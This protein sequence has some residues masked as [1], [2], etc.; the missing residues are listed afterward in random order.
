MKNHYLYSI[1]LILFGSYQVN[2]QT[3]G[4][5]VHNGITRNYILYVPSSYQ[6]G[7]SWPLVHVLHGFT[8]SASTIMNVSGFNA[9]AD[10]AEFIV[11]YPNGVGNAWNTNSGMT[12][13]STAD[14][15]GFIGALTDT[16]QL[17]YNIDTNR[18]YS[19]GF[20]AGGY[21]SHRLACEAPRCYAAVASVA[22]TM[23]VNAFNACAPSRDISVMQIHGT[24][25]AIV[26][27]NGSAQ[28]GKSVDD[29]IG[30]WVGNN[31]CATPPAVQLLPNI[32]TQDNSTV[33][34]SVYAPCNNATEVNLYKVIGGGHQWPGTNSLLGG[35]GAINRDISASAEI[36][37]F[38]SRFS[39]PLPSS[40]NSPEFATSADFVLAQ[41][42][43]AG[44]VIINHSGNINFDAEVYDV[45]GK[46]MLYEAASGSFV[47]NQETLPGGIYILKA[48]AGNSVKTFKV[49][50]PF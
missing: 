40:I 21:M 9:I 31:S 23:S 47:L 25:D 45:T 22:G 41:D 6:P 15:I 20:S 4:T 17:L 5:I 8:Q 46:K 48:I 50:I 32:N 29:V 35:L 24:S 26:S 7:N 2:S 12:G 38:F 36:W 37:N 10:T 30:L 11:A 13:G 19:C 28:G 18:V 44:T 14:D 34:K 39:C 43:T 27:Y 16:L 42:Y 1:I 3:N 33:E 49:C